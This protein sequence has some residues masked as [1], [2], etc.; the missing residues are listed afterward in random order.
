MSKMRFKDLE[1]VLFFQKNYKR[2]IIAILI[3]SLLYAVFE[4]LNIAVLFPIITSV[5]NIDA[6]VV[7]GGGIIKF[8]NR[9]IGI[10]PVKDTFIAACILVI[11][12]VVLKN[13]FRYLH[14]VLCAYSSYKIWEDTQKQLYAKYINADYRYFLDHKHGEIVYRLDHAPATTGGILKLI[15]QFITEILKILVIG[16]ILFSMSFWVTCGVIII[17][18]IFYFFTR[19]ISKKISYFLG[20]GRMEAVQEQNILI[21]EMINGIKQIK[22][23]LGE[24]RWTLRFYKAVGSFF[25]LAKKD[26][27]WINMPISVLE[28]FA[29]TALSI[30]LIFVRKFSPYNLASNLPFIGVFAYAFQRVM[31]S[32]SLITTLRMQIMGELPVLEILR[33][34]IKEEMS[35]LK[36]GDKFIKAFNKSIELHNVSFS[37]PGRAEALHNISVSFEKNKCIAIAGPSGSGKTTMVN[38]LIRLFDPTKGAILVDG[39]DLRNYKRESWLTK[40]GFV[41]QDTFIFHASVRDNIAFGLEAADIDDIIRVAKIANAH[42]FISKLPEGYNTI[43]GE[44]GMKLS[45]G[46]QQRIAIARAMLRNPQILIFDEATSALDNVSQSLIQNSINKIVKDHTVI[47]IAHRLSTIVNADKIIVLDSGTIKE[48]GFHSELIARKEFYW[49]LYNNEQ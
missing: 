18:G 12:V 29:L 15:P 6:S 44:K 17:A 3:L 36:D 49:A 38:L 45:G 46:E 1:A 2:Y 33:S 8:L 47:L 40:I 5:I 32:L 9:L 7:E 26:T 25:K 14:M 22:V 16:V 11:I 28:I 20:K 43:V 48:T 37:Y 27:L 39:V 41:S 31:P 42:D 35:Y 4:G 21:N 23:F 10:I 19:G 34:V 13:I 30:F 24:R